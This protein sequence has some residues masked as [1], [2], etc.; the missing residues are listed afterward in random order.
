MRRFLI[1]AV[2][3]GASVASLAGAKEAQEEQGQPPKGQSAL[4][5]VFEVLR[6][7]YRFENDGTGTKE[8][9][10]RV[11]ILTQA[12]AQQFP[13][14]TF[15]Y[16][17]SKERLNVQ[18]IRILRHDGKAVGV[19][20]AP[21]PN[22]HRIFREGS[23]SGF[24][25]YERSLPLP[26]VS[27]GDALE[28]DVETVS[29]AAETPG[30][31]SEAY[32]FSPEGVLDEQLEIDVPID[33]TVKLKTKPGLQV[34]PNAE[35]G[36]RIYS[37]RKLHQ[38]SDFEG[39]HRATS[40]PSQEAPDVQI[41]SFRNWEEVG[42]WYAEM[43]SSRRIPSPEVKAKAEELTV[44]LKSDSEKVAALY[45]FVSKK[46]KY[47][48]L[49]SVGIAGYEPRTATDVLRLGYGDCKD[50]DTLLAALLEA[51]GMHA[52]SVLINP[53][54]ELDP[55][56]PSPWPFTHVITML[57]LGKEELWMDSSSGVPFRM[58]LPILQKKKALVIPPAGM[59][60]F[61]ETP[62]DDSAK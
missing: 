2:L 59:P 53:I 54:R 44:G 41:S 34:S 51:E 60:H 32:S 26:S 22:P 6:T 42:R 4:P 52:S 50:K 45:D 12:G 23:S 9:N 47:L 58:L 11:R 28:Y 37:W 48:S 55:E 25:F 13:E 19:E 10:A 35:N 62:A 27:P 43:E 39:E 21:P 49:V 57:H 7:R 61:E 29:Y 38:A 40:N 8:I 46:I 3:I 24:D 56:M 30:N 33:R 5:Y 36:R 17:P 20:T 31:F 16:K 15:Q 18:Y 14:L 1:T